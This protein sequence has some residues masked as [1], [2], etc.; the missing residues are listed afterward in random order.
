MKQSN[1]K[2]ITGALLAVSVASIGIGFGAW[3]I[4]SDRPALVEGN[5]A[6]DVDRTVST[7]IRFQDLAIVDGSIS[8]GPTIDKNGLIQSA[9]NEEDL[10]FSFSFRTETDSIALDGKTIEFTLES[11]E[12]I[13]EAVSK[14]YIVLPLNEGE[15]VVAFT[16]K[17]EANGDG[18][19]VNRFVPN[20]EA[21]ASIVPAYDETENLYTITC[22][23][24][25]GAAFKS[26]NPVLDTPAYWGNEGDHFATDLEVQGA[27][28][29]LKALVDGVHFGITIFGNDP[30]G[31]Y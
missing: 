2:I 28:D 25:W 13:K 12:K 27:L 11:N 20:A 29:E 14:D 21:P 15:K 31:N 16:A 3:A 30:T 4:G 7:A 26:H 24:S 23:F 5:I 18:T 8:F 19:I 9:T 17:S 6:L 10:S 22:S 1:K